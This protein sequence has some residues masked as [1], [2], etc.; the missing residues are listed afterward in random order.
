[1]DSHKEFFV[2]YIER[3]STR[4]IL[5]EDYYEVVQEIRKSMMPKIGIEK[6]DMLEY[7]KSILHMIKSKFRDEFD[8]NFSDEELQENRVKNIKGLENTKVTKII[9]KALNNYKEKHQR[10]NIYFDYNREFKFLDYFH[11]IA[12]ENEEFYISSDPNDLLLAYEKISTCV[13]PDGDNIANI[14]QWLVSPFTY[15]AY[16]RDTNKEGELVINNRAIVYID[17]GNRVAS[18]GNIYGSYN[19][20]FQVSIMKWLKENHFSIALE[21]SDWFAFHDL[22]YTES[23]L[24]SV[25]DFVDFFNISV[26]DKEYSKRISIHSVPYYID[27]IGDAITGHGYGKPK[28]YLLDSEIRSSSGMLLYSDEA[29]CGDCGEVVSSDEYDYDGE[30]C[31][32]CAQFTSRNYCEDC[33]EHYLDSDFDFEEDLCSSCAFERAEKDNAD[34]EYERERDEKLLEEAENGL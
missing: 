6:L 28:L 25:K 21:P 26:V 10:N 14:F 34:E 12:N 4:D 32:Y 18:I 16:T 15:I 13:S 2:E 11:K 8:Y 31:D 19:V 20:M 30:V 22:Y 9:S 23:G 27:I 7:K 29:I 24:S 17:Y 5:R 3:Y 33:G 1:M